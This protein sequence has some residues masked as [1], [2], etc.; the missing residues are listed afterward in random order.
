MPFKRLAVATAA[1]LACTAA[2]CN[3]NQGAAPG[4]AQGFPPTLVKLS[5]AG[6]SAISDTSEYV[7][8][9]KS[10]R[11]TAIQP[12]IDGQITQILVKSGDRVQQG[13]PI[14]QI[15][16]RRQEA[17]VSSQEAERAARE[18]NVTFARQQQERGDD[19]FAAGA[20]SK[21]GARTVGDGPSH[22]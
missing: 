21:A 22:R 3:R 14:L 6:E 12:Q 18:A 1:L 10:L 17:A 5:V 15:D 2:A 16:P 19:L 11:S 13:A 4:G 20:I 7:A 9:L 8:T